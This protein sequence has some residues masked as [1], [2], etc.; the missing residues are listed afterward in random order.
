MVWR[1]VVGGGEL[2]PGID[3][4]RQ[5]QDTAREG[6]GGQGMLGV[7]GRECGLGRRE[8]A[9]EVGVGPA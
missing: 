9:C 7:S 4:A 5:E 3:T 6:G 1:G 2:Q 8:R